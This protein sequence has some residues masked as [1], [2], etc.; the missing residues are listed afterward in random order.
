MSDEIQLVVVMIICD[1][2]SLRCWL[3]F[4]NFFSVAL[5]A[6]SVFFMVVRVFVVV[7]VSL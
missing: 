1:G 4:E 2:E 6:F 5:V 7:A 3:Q